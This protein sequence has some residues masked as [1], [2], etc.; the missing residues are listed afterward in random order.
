MSQRRSVQADYFPRGGLQVAPC[1]APHFS[2]LVQRKVSK[3]NTPRHPGP[4]APQSD[5]PPSGAAPGVGLKGRP[6]PFIPRS[7]SMPRDP[8]RDT[9]TRPPDGDWASV[10]AGG[11]RYRVSA[12]DRRVVNGAALATCRGEEA[13]QGR[14]C[15]AAQGGSRQCPFART[16][17]R[18]ECFSVGAAHGR[19]LLMAIEPVAAM[20]RSYRFVPGARACTSQ[21]GQ[22]R[23]PVHRF[24]L[25]HR[26]PQLPCTPSNR[27]TTCAGN[28]ASAARA[29][30]RSSFSGMS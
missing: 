22:R 5:S 17:G 23:S 9:C 18:F 29:A 15:G 2:L 10:Q 20:G 26:L 11:L 8:L 3:R 19:E 14:W 12:V 27:S 6:C 25:Y 1:T 4:I 16:V 7:A 13:V 30:R 24:A 21:D 28:T